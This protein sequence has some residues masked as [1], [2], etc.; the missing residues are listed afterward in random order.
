MAQNF[1]NIL[2]KTI[3]KLQIITFNNVKRRNAMNQLFYKEVT[4]VLNDAAKNDS[5]G[6]VALTNN[7]QFYSTGN[8]T[9]IIESVDIASQVSMPILRDFFYAFIDFPKLLFAVVNGPAIGGGCTST[10]LCD[11]VYASNK[12]HS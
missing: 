5:I 4:S 2:T 6:A 10:A 1:T 12:V 7:G 9:A 11:I 3:G 8:D